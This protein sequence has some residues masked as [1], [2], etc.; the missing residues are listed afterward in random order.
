MRE[1]HCSVG[2]FIQYHQSFVVRPGEVS[3]SE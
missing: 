1:L 2:S 3:S